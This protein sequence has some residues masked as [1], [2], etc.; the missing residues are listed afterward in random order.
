MEPNR[1]DSLCVFSFLPLAVITAYFR[2]LLTGNDKKQLNCPAYGS[3]FTGTQRSL[4]HIQPGGQSV[5]IEHTKF[6]SALF[7]NLL[8]FRLWYR[9]LPAATQIRNGAQ[10]PRSNA[11]IQLRTRLIEHLPIQSSPIKFDM[12]TTLHFILSSYPQT[13]NSSIGT[14]FSHINC[15]FMNKNR[16]YFPYG[17]ILQAKNSN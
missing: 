6:R 12:T 7:C 1:R 11:V 10:Q 2:T 17:H 9:A 14:C 15:L 5:S 13:Q 3:C 4:K 8:C 16:P